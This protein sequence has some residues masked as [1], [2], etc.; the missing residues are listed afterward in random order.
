M[1]KIMYVLHIDDLD[2]SSKNL[3]IDKVSKFDKVT[4][5]MDKIHFDGLE[6]EED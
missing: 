3:K 2:L 4:G 5:S 6:N 1:A